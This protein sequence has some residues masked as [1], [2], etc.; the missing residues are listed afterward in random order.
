MPDELSNYNHL[1]KM[2]APKEVIN[3]LTE[4]RWEDCLDELAIAVYELRIEMATRSRDTGGKQA[5]P[6]LDE[7]DGDKSIAPCHKSPVPSLFDIVA[8]MVNELLAE[9]ETNVASLDTLEEGVLVRALGSRESLSYP[10]RCALVNQGR[11]ILGST[12][13]QDG[14]PEVKRRKLDSRSLSRVMQKDVDEWIVLNERSLRDAMV[15][16]SNTSSSRGLVRL[17]SHMDTVLPTSYL[18]STSR[19][20]DRQPVGGFTILD[21]KRAHKLRIQPSVEAFTSTFASMT[22]NILKGLDWTN[23]VV[24]G[25]I[26]LGVLL[27]VDA[28]GDKVGED[29]TA[30]V[31]TNNVHTNIQ[32]D[33]EVDGMDE[34]NGWK[35]SDIDIYIYGLDVTA[36]NEKI[37]HIFSIFQ[38]NLQPGQSIMVVKNARTITF[39]SQYPTRRIQI[40]LKKVHYPKEVLLNFDLDICAMG[41]DG[42]EV[43]MLP[44]TVRALESEDAS[45]NYCNR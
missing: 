35:H 5:Q 45:S 8:G 3:L 29:D 24:A 17:S 42:T 27:T 31:G 34:I 26:V 36:A 18:D 2:T 6:N 39:L 14:P 12:M 40:V 33:G 4:E 38:A 43:W 28:E 25:G 32:I 11:L 9:D 19:C 16:D 20:L 30:V 41:F 13:R 44:R 21:A 7:S 1:A 22:G 23:V 15:N 37:R 10:V